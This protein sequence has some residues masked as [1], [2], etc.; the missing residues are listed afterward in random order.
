MPISAPN[1]DA[2]ICDYC[3]ELRLSIQAQMH[4]QNCDLDLWREVVEKMVNI[5]AKPSLQ[6]PLRIRKPE[7]NCPMGN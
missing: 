5:K 1:T 4:N 3:E 6:S 7:F 2:M